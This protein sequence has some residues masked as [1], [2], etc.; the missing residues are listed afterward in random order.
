M[1]AIHSLVKKALRYIAKTPGA[2]LLRD[3]K[4]RTARLCKPCWELQYCPYGPVVEDFPLLPVLRSEAEGHN[5]YLRSCLASG[6][7]ADGQLTL[8]PFFGQLRGIL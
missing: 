4:K 2:G 6:R 1:K 8:S 5:D 3:W 7:L